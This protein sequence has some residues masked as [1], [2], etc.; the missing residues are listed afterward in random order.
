MRIS[1][2]PRTAVLVFLGYLLVFYSVWAITGVD[3][4]R[5]ADNADTVLK[6]Y[7]IPLACGAVFL[8]IAVSALGWWRPALFETEKATPRWLLIG[9]AFMAVA[10][11]ITLVASDKS[12]TTVNMFW[13]I[14][15]GSL[16]VGFCEE[17]ATRVTAPDPLPA[18]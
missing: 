18:T 11:V 5:V 7:V 3:Y 10:A 17:L 1:P 12:K 8:V 6:W 15:I 16:L 9:P 13:L 4:K 2:R 14:L